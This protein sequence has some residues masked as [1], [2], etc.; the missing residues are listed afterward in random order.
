MGEE[1]IRGGTEV[2]QRKADGG[3]PSNADVYKT[4]EWY[5]NK[6]FKL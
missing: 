2:L 1:T 5:A 6:L 3:K 4:C